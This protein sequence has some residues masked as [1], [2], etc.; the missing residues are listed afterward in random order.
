MING[1]NNTADH[2]GP[3]RAWLGVRSV[4][5]GNT[6]RQ[7]VKERKKWGERKAVFIHVGPQFTGERDVQTNIMWC[8]NC[9]NGMKPET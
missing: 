9:P 4:N 6:A 3:A 7:R 2:E 1:I 8:G 5:G